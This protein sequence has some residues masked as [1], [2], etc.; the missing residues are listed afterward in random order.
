MYIKTLRGAKTKPENKL[1]TKNKYC[2][3]RFP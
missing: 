3:K 1:G 2:R